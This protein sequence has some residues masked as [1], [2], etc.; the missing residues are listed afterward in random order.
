MREDGSRER[1]REPEFGQVHWLICVYLFFSA[2]L[3]P[4]DLA[5]LPWLEPWLFLSIHVSLPGFLFLA[6]K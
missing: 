1:E 2:R 6:H 3:V 5:T 4:E